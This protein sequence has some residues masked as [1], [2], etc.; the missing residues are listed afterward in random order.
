MLDERA[1]LQNLTVCEHKADI[2]GTLIG[3]RIEIARSVVYCAITMGIRKTLLSSSGIMD[4]HT[5]ISAGKRR[6]RVQ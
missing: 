3:L 5:R 6:C 2:P 1:K 4:V